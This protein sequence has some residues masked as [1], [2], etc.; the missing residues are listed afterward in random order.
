MA[1]QNMPVQG[2]PWKQWSKQRLLENAGT[3]H[4]P[5]LTLKSVRFAYCEWAK[6]PLLAGQMNWA[7]LDRFSQV[8]ST[9]AAHEPSQL[10]SSTVG[11]CPRWQPKEAVHLACGSLLDVVV[12]AV[13]APQNSSLMHTH[14]G[15]HAH[16]P[17]AA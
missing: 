7:Y 9:T 4:A 10:A 5:K 12:W 17:F 2:A 8:T 13:E 14:T 15:P 11:P 1:V 3:Q 6:L 16:T